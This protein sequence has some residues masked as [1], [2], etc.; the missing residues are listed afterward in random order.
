MSADFQRIAIVNRGE[1]AMRLMHAIREFNL[2]RGTGITAIALFT[3]PDRRA[4]FVREADES[5]QPRAGHFRRRCRR[6]AEAHL[7]GLRAAREG[8]GGRPGG[9]G[10]A[11]VGIRRRARR[12]RRA[13]RP[14][15]YHL[16]RAEQPRAPAAWRQDLGQADRRTGG[17]A[18]DAV[19]RRGGRDARRGV[20]ARP[21]DGLPGGRQGVGRRRRPR[22]PAG[23]ER[24]GTG[25]G[26]RQRAPRGG[27]DVRR[28]DGVRGALARRRPPRRS[29]D[30]G[31]PPRRDVGAR[32]PRLHDPAPVP[33]ADCRGAVAGAARDRGR[34]AQGGGH[35]P[36]PRGRLPGRG[37]GRVPLRPVDPPVLL[38]GGQPAPP[39]RAS[40]HRAHHR[41][42]PGEAVA[43]RGARRPPRRRAAVDDGPC[44][45]GA[46]ERGE[47]GC[48]IL[49]LAWRDRA[50]PAADRAGA[51]GRFWRGRGGLR[52]AG[53]RVDVRQAVHRGPHSR[54]GAGPAEARAGRE[55]DRDQGR[56]DQPGVPAGAA[57]PRRG[58][59]R[60]RRRRLAR[61]PEPAAG[62]RTRGSCRD[63]AAAG[64]HRGV[65]RGVRGR[66]RGV[67][68]RGGEDA[69]DVPARCGAAGRGR[70]PGPPLPVQGVPAGT[71][72]VPDRRRGDADRSRGRAAGDVRTVD[73][74]RGAPLPRP[75]V[76][77]GI[78][79]PDRSRRRAAPH[80]QS[81]LGHCP[82]AGSRD[83]RRPRRQGWR[84]RGGRRPPG[85]TRVDE[86]GT[87]GHRPVLRHGA[88]GAGDGQ[89]AGRRR[90]AAGP[91]RP[92]AGRKRRRR[93]PPR[94]V[95][96]DLAA[97]VA[98]RS[99]GVQDPG[100]SERREGRHRRTGARAGAPRSGPAREPAPADA[101]VRRGPGRNEAAGQRVRPHVAGDGRSSMPSTGATKTA[102]CRSSRTSPR[103]S[104]VTRRRRPEKR[105]AR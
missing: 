102:C 28:R 93:G 89:R 66:T 14:V 71:A 69:A 33:E 103:C 88:P 29:A 53:V 24:G 9:R 11:G 20:G 79:P 49:G 64:R 101:R 99:A 37:D 72:G 63:R 17:P 76:R 62:R 27:P 68:L 16:H 43:A 75:V 1:P 65:R 87:G 7:P 10:H 90:G 78:H 39:G 41:R 4:R 59:R 18:G 82:R 5:Y 15:G 34:G 95:R 23:L 19:G 85:R 13:L 105:A 77:A 91:R 70:L 100:D 97:Q 38:H 30:A 57:R 86:D 40:R 83:G 55:R 84:L 58:P 45:R 2:E 46:A 6:A 26:V 96:G 12:F 50:V 32:H 44:H 73:H 22:H 81:R 60:S 48:R 21:A 56:F 67:L 35:P 98:G 52:P 94:D 51:A 3:E 25:G 80:L 104:A 54:G 74:A 92:G 47:R 36:V 61:S 31:R 8:A 42:R